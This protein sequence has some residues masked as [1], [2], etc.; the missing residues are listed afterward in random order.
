[1]KKIKAKDIIVPAAALLIFCL[2][3]TALL[4]GT[5]LITKDKIAQNAVEKENSL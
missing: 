4:A 5:N 2:V 1:M 3:A